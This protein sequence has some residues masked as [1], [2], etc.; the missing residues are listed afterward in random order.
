MRSRV[1]AGPGGPGSAL[2]AGSQQDAELARAYADVLL[3]VTVET[4]VAIM[5]ETVRH[6]TDVV[7]ANSQVGDRSTDDNRTYQR[8]ERELDPIRWTGELR[9]VASGGLSAASFSHST[10]EQAAC[11]RHTAGA[12]WVCAVRCR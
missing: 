10:Q 12:S 3:E 6:L 2:I 8:L 11:G 4:R 5:A 1:H 7:P 9:S